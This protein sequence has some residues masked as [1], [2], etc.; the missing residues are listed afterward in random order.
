MKVDPPDL[1][2]R[3]SQDSFITSIRVATHGAHSRIRVWV[4]GAC[5]GQLTVRNDEVDMLTA[6]LIPE[7]LRTSEEIVEE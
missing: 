1:V 6:R 2:I 7:E 4:R 3:A 5:A